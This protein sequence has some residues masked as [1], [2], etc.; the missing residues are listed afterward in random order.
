M[1][2]LLGQAPMSGGIAVVADSCQVVRAGVEG[3]DMAVGR[4][5][6]AK[7]MDGMGQGTVFFSREG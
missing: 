3:D 4:N 5:A 1:Q 2:T 7:A 6:R